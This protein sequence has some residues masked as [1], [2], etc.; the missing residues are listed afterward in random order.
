MRRTAIV[1]A[2]AAFAIPAA[3]MLRPAE[4]GVRWVAGA[5]FSVGGIQF[6]LGFNGP[7]RY[8]YSP[9]YYYRTDRSLSYRGYECGS[10]C[11]LKDRRHYHGRS[12][13]VVRQHFSR[14]GFDPYYAWGYVTHGYGGR[15]NSP[16]PS[17]HRYN[18]DRGR[19][20]GYNRGH[21]R[22]RHRGR[23]RFRYEPKRHRRHQHDR[24]CRH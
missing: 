22:Y 1:F 12:C 23:D 20:R 17:Y 7:Y 9:S 13:P 21:D 11:Y 16:P 18:Y 8:G 5:D 6:S 24:S 3:G 10:A 15:Y 14:H 19:H 2:I 4:A